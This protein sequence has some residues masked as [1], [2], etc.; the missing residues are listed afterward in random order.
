MPVEGSKDI[1]GIHPRLWP[2]AGRAWPNL[3]KNGLG[4]SSL[5]YV[6]A[7]CSAHINSL[8]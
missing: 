2:S 5:F 6:S 4:H 1:P 3:A 8:S 7:L